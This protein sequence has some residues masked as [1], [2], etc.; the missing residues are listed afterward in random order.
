MTLEA[1]APVALT[2]VDVL[3]VD[4]DPGT[5]AIVREALEDEGYHVMTASTGPQALTH[6]TKE[7]PALVLLDLDLPE[8][9]GLEVCDWLRR[10][11]ME[12]TVIFMSA[13]GTVREDAQRYRAAGCLPKPF[14]VAH[15]LDVVERFAL[16]PR[17]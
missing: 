11:G 12:A 10:W 3:V 14:D 15:L 2:S 9:S 6:I 13:T 5:R 8:L 16:R 7:Q 4:A 1:P 17:V